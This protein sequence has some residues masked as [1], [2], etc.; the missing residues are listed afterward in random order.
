MIFYLWPS[1]AEPPPTN[2]QRA[3]RAHKEMRRPLQRLSKISLALQF[4]PPLPILQSRDDPGF[5]KPQI[6]ARRSTA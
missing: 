4:P 5:D 6:A 1:K 2:S 3:T